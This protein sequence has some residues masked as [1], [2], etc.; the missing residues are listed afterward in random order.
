MKKNTLP[1]FISFFLFLSL[2]SKNSFGKILTKFERPQ[3][4]I[5]LQ[6][7]GGASFFSLNYDRAF[8]NN[9]MSFSAGFGYMGSSTS[10]KIGLAGEQKIFSFP[11]KFNYIGLH[12]D[13]HGLEI[14]G[15]VTLLYSPQGLNID[16]NAIT[17]GAQSLGDG[18]FAPAGLATVAYRFQGSLINFRLGCDVHIINETLQPKPFVSLGFSF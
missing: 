18:T 16:S 11:I 7:L 4:T 3:N 15:G 1:F 13:S 10:K 8:L 17:Q 6:V 5:Y 14:G 9:H 12:R 2:S